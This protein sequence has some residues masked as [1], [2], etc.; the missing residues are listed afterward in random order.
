MSRKLTT[1]SSLYNLRNEARRWLKALQAGD[2][3]ARRRLEAAVPAA[4]AEPALRD[5][6]FALAR[7]HGLPGWA[8]LRDAVEDMKRSHAERVELVLRSADWAGDHA[9]GARLLKHWPEIGKDSLYTAAA[10]GDLAEVERRLAADPG[11]TNR[12]GGPL[13][14][15]P[16]L[17]LAYSRLPGSET[18]A[19]E[20]AR[21]L[22]DQGA[23]PNARWI[24]PWG[25]PAFTVL[26]GLIG[27]G[28]GDQPPHPRARELSE[29]LIER[30]A[31]PFDFQTLYNI[32]ITRD[33]TDWLEFLWSQSERRGTLNAWHDP[34]GAD[35]GGKISVLNYLLGNATAYN[36][37]KRAKWLLAHGADPNSPHAYSKR[38][39]REEAL[40]HG[41]FE[42]AGLLEQF[43]AETTALEGPSAFRAACMNLDREAARAIIA[44]RPEYLRDPEPMLTAARAGR[45][46]VVSLLL[47]LGVNADVA[48][49]IDQRGLQVAVAGGSLEVVKLL[50]A[51]GADI[52][53]PTTSVGGGAMG[54]ASHFDRRE[55]AAFLAPLSHDV[56]E[57]T[58]LGFKDR[59]AE[60]FAA[61]PALVNVRHAEMGCTPLF[62]LPAD[63][64]EALKMAAF[65]FY[66]GA[67][68]N[69][70]DF[71]GVTPEE[72]WR[73][74]GFIALADFLQ[75][76]G[77]RHFSGMGG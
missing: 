16:L 10:S 69:I 64:D 21:R 60:L 63:E 1:R 12:K 17:Y 48:D 47:D 41:H 2:A 43:G 70:P 66:Y 38:P 8:A 58:F 4:P 28:E 68:P 24:G 39:Q 59:L 29:L 27:E 73:R 45:A 31:D 61:D 74:N 14:R 75:V 40:I 57:L 37:L 49:K 76:G 26:T 72:A 50:V 15:E 5:V 30:G 77:V 6:Q 51:H 52:D 22:L 32:S 20:I 36:H 7:E 33:D 71:A 53:R 46:D 54:Y 18:H 65:L 23:D 56:H 35:I 9:T 11:A 19:L 44:S 25:P 55:I 67:D 3:D 34:E 13:D 42:M 62:V